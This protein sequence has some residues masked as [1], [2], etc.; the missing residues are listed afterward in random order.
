MSRPDPEAVEK[1]HRF[2]AV[3]CNNRAWEL[4]EQTSRSEEETHEMRTTAHAADYH[5]AVLGPPVN[6]V[7]AR[8]LL[9]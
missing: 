5:W 7:R 8:I 9:A 6:R 4:T 1:M 3:E 2:F